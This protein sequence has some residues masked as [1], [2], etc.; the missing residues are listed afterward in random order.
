M[1]TAAKE[2]A[3]LNGCCIS[4]KGNLTKTC[5]KFQELRKDVENKEDNIPG[6]S[7]VRKSNKVRK[8]ISHLELDPEPRMPTELG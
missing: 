2:F 5:D 6:L 8:A 1:A 7:R 3:K 4:G